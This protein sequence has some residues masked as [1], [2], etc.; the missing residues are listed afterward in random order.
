MVYF[1]TQYSTLQYNIHFVLMTVLF[2]NI[3]F[4]NLF[5]W[6]NLASHSTWLRLVKD[7]GLD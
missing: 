2:N 4:F 6:L 3:Y 7:Y 5:L 1:Y